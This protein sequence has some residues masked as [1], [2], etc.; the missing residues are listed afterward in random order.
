MNQLLLNLTA[1]PQ[2]TLDNFICG[3]NAELLRGLGDAL[4]L[5][6][7]ERFYY[8]WGLEGSGRTHLLK[9]LVHAADTKQRQAVYIACA[10]AEEIE[11]GLAHHDVVAVDDVERL[12]EPG[13]IAL[14]NLYNLM[15]EGQGMLLVSG[16]NPPGQL[17][18][19]DDL[20]TRLGWGLVYQVHALTDEEKSR[21]LQ[22]HA[23]GRGMKLPDE[24]VNYLLSHGR[25]D[26]PSLLAVIEALDRLSLQTQRPISVP[27][28]K[29]A[30]KAPPQ[31]GEGD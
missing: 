27:L 5:K 4:E 20:V 1:P 26:L 10:P 28:L 11:T 6:H 21:A 14:F 29:E 16:D 12:D 2:P 18:L 3:A 15:R 25:R 17:K 9:S 13:Q 22:S 7:A 24:V 8:L 30:I 23:A 19:R 31:S